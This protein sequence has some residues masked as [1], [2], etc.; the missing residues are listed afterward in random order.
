MSRPRLAIG[1][2]NY[3]GQAHAW[4]QAVRDHLPADAWSFAPDRGGFNF[5]VDRRLGPLANRNPVLRSVRSNRF[6]RGTTHV[7]VDGFEVFF[8]LKRRG[9]LAG[10]LRQL[11]RA[12]KQVA[13]IS[14]GSDTRDP[15]AHLARVGHSYFRE[16]DD[17]WRAALT[18]STAETRAIA[19][20][21]GL[22]LFYS[23]PDLA[24]DLPSGRWL[25]TTIDVD[26]WRSDQPLLERRRPRVLHVPSRRNPPIKGT[27]YIEPPLREL[28]AAGVIE[29]VSPEGV[30]HS[31]MRA[32]VQSV[33]VVV[34][35]ILM[36][37]YGVAAVEAMAA[38][39]VV[40][41]SLDDVR[42]LLEEAPEFVET[43]PSGVR[44]AILRIV[45]ERDAM[46][47]SAERNLAF[48]RRWHDGRESA[49][50]LSGFLGLAGEES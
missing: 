21:S 47:E 41:G 17:A 46:R 9:K 49:A 50:R 16:G 24:H 44:D 20:G 10:D 38:G 33:D 39:R 8:H 36:G 19:E 1:P 42:D 11:R 37:S 25:P 26:G 7:A 23:T 34:D 29:Y 13:L 2:A 6:F 48:V 5:A 14:H 12:G 22:P 18:A 30:P 4:A 27:Q 35:Q 43:T 40:V 45:E 32:L 3:A 31:E 28:D 15:Q